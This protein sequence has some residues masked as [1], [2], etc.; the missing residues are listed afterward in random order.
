MIVLENK[1]VEK[2]ISASESMELLGIGLVSISGRRANT[3][4]KKGIGNG[5]LK[6]LVKFYKDKIIEKREGKII[7]LLGSHT[8]YIHFFDVKPDILTIFYVN[9]KDKLI[10]Y[11]L[12][13]SIS[14]KLVRT[15]CS[16]SSDTE[17]NTLCENIIPKVSGI[18]ALFI[19]SRAG[20]TLFTKISEQKKFLMSK[21]IQI[22]GFISAIT[23]FS[24]E[25][26]GKESGGHLEE[27]NF[28]NQQFI[29]IIKNEIIFA[30]LLEKNKKLNQI[31]RFMDLLAEEFM[32]SY[33]NYLE[34][35]NGDIEP[36]S[37]FKPIVDKYFVI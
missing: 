16:N 9:E 15:F 21:Y 34:D 31:N 27:I 7:D 5:L 28:E 23:A 35:F 3:I 8:I 10:R 19:I 32:D 2:E 33:R 37:S 18:S 25:L 11:D 12:L 17:I 24:Q 36:F 30:Y 1:L 13:C 22:G 20:H 6:T 14:N 26:I 29:L 4:F